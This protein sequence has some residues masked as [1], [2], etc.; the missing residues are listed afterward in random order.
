MR[1]NCGGIGPRTFPRLAQE[2]LGPVCRQILRDQLC[3]LLQQR[4]LLPR[5]AVRRTCCLAG[6]HDNQPQRSHTQL[7]RHGD[8]G[9]HFAYI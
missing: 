8:L 7:D 2:L 1:L 6:I 9:Y 3:C 4:S 5:C